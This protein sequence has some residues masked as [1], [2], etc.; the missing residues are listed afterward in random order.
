MKNDLEAYL[1]T[2]KKYAQSDIQSIDTKLG[3]LP[4]FPMYVVFKDEPGKTYTYTD[5]GVGQ[6]SQIYPNKDVIDRGGVFKHWEGQ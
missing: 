3:K 2:Q 1:T 6:W 5:R 4:T